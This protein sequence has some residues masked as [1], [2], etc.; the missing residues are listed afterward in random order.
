MAIASFDKDVEVIQKLDDE[1][2][3]VQG[4]TPEELK[5]KFDQAAIWLKE[6]INTVL[7]PGITGTGSAGGGS[8][9]S[10][11]GAGVDDFPGSDVQAILNAF[12]DAL[13]DRYTRAE[14]NSYVGQET[15][16]LVA[17]V[18]VDLTTGVITVTKK[19]GT[20]QTFDTA[21]EKV[22]ATMALVEEDGGTYL[23]IT[24]QDGSQTRTDV[25]SL[26]DTYT[27]QNSTEL[28]FSVDGTGNNRTV[29]ATIRPA[30]IGLD[31]FKAEVTE[32]LEGYNAE[33][34]ASASAARASETAAKASETAAKGSETAAAGSASA[35]SQKA[36]AAETSA[37]SAAQ[38]ASAASA[39]AQS[40][41]SNASQALGAKGEAQAQAALA[42]SWAEGGTGVREGENTNNA[43]Y[44]SDRAQDAAG[45]GV[46]SFNGRTGAV[47]P[48]S[49][50]YTA[51]QVGAIPASQK[52]AAGG[53]AELDGS[54]KLTDAQKPG[55]TAAE[56]GA[57][58]I[59]GGT[60]TGD[61]YMGSN[62]LLLKN[63]RTAWLA[64]INEH[65]SAPIELGNAG[66]EGILI[67]AQAGPIVFQSGIAA[68][69][70]TGSNITSLSEP[71][72]DTDAANKGYVD[73][74]VSEV[75]AA[76]VGAYTKEETL[77]ED[78]K[79]LLGLSGTATPDD[80]FVATLPKIGDIKITVRTDLGDN[81]LLCNGE[82]ISEEDY[83]ELY[84]IAKGFGLTPSTRD[85]WTGT[86]SYNSWINSIAYG[87][88]YYVA[89]GKYY[90]GSSSCTAR[91]AYATS[92]SGA[93]TTKD[94]WKA[95]SSSLSGQCEINCVGYGNGYWVVGGAYCDGS[96]TY[97]RIAYATSPNGTWT[98]QDLWAGNSDYALR[99]VIYA[100]STWIA[101]GRGSSGSGQ[102]AYTTS[103]SGTWTTKTLSSL[104]P[105]GVVYANGY[106]L[107]PGKDDYVA[108]LGY[109]PESGLPEIDL[110]N[111][112]AYIKALE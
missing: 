84:A 68:I 106:L 39:S 9:A 6:Y 47:L 18:G 56:V 4:L 11:I 44:W 57:L 38:S 62:G 26:I 59:S 13:T 35:A 75:T 46:S 88:G 3:D 87:N 83:P 77:S 82:A 17:A 14:T 20:A 71:T 33:S 27:F 1:P 28:S 76:Q 103:L 74:K 63:D 70:V 8:G 22:P 43:K 23:V 85:V 25:S 2:N 21:L 54:G 24:N 78:T 81:W 64:A 12:N 107:I 30:S 108:V 29:T 92:L 36:S 61:L 55:Y 111:A 96:Y 97:G 32:A 67:T 94:L 102:I 34:A 105:L 16:D 109:S 95:S 79:T 15:H 99:G 10:N 110:P 7:L 31:R 19:D 50:D 101:V 89:V 90:D 66:L 49:G 80:A 42:Q 37:A 112:Y 72:A 52:G 53:V 65:P 91:I 93:W 69:D 98:T 5:Q 45:G 48:Q 51:Q 100:N 58:P 41:Q 73:N 40:A 86:S 60:M 104:V